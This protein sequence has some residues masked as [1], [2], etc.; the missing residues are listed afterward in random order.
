MFKATSGEFYVEEVH[1][2]FTV[3]KWCDVNTPDGFKHAYNLI[4]GDALLVC[5]G[6]KTVEII[7]TKI[8]NL[9]DKNQIV[10]YY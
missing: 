3:D 5:D 1:N 8:D 4:T 9:V 7:I 6:D 2:S 10:C